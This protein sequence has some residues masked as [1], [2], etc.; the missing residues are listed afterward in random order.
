MIDDF[1]YISLISSDIYVINIFSAILYNTMAQCYGVCLLH[2]K[3]QRIRN[4]NMGVVSIR[5]STAS[6]AAPIILIFWYAVMTAGREK[7]K[8]E[9]GNQ[10]QCCISLSSHFI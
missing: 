8:S 2:K 1:S 10:N 5:K 9:I 6:V 3:C 4:K 7:S